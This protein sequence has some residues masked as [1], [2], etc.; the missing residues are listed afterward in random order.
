MPP[1]ACRIVTFD[2]KDIIR[3]RRV[4]TMSLVAERLADVRGIRTKW[5][6]N[7]WVPLGALSLIGGPPGTAKSML[8][9]WI[10]SMVTR[11]ELA[12]ELAR[13]PS[14]VLIVSSEDGVSDTI[15]PRLM[16][17][18]ANL[19]RV[20]FTDPADSG[21]EFPGRLDDL[22]EFVIENGIRLIV[23]D[24]VAARLS[25]GLNANMD[26]DVRRA[27]EPVVGA[28]RDL[29]TSIIGIMHMRKATNVDA[30]SAMLG[31]TAFVG[32][33]RSV[34]ATFDD[35]EGSFL[36]SCAKLN[37]GKKPDS[38]RYEVVSAGVLED[39][40][41]INTAR[42]RW[43]GQTDKTVD[44]ALAEK[45]ARLAGRSVPRKAAALENAEEYLKRLLADGPML[46]RDVAAK[47]TAAGHSET[48]LARAKSAL[49][50]ISRKTREGWMW[51]LR[52]P[53]PYIFEEEL[54]DLPSGL[55]VP[56]NSLD[57]EDDEA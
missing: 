23:L 37:L 11:G 8:S 36:L 22:R 20:H 31:S 42:L 4:T 15:K 45:A 12:G 16:A 48:T 2:T 5:L 7:G 46:Q 17:L 30:V 32:L 40:E 33:A 44:D 39:D 26:K 53:N 3:V 10:A 1:R 47:A 19:G 50:A 34:M 27:L 28:L 21:L 49:G 9:V 41:I 51:S 24:P 14:G 57:T 52:N 13:K 56:K 43:L 29:G 18:D 38:L 35:G 55:V 25:D 6:W 54:D